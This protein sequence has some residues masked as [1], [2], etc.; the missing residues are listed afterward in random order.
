[1]NR[2][3]LGGFTLIEL[4]VVIA[5]IAILAAILFPL[6]SSAKA[7][8]NQQRCL[9][10]LRQLA[11]AVAMYAGDN[12]GRSPNPRVCIKWPSWEGS[13]G[14]KQLVYPREGQIW[15]YLRNNDVY[16]CP[17][18]R[19]QPAPEITGKPKNYALSYSMNYMF[20]DT[21]TRQTVILDTMRRP[22]EVLLL[23]HESREKINDGDFNWGSRWDIPTK[24]HYE[25]STV[26]YV[27][28]HAK[29]CSYDDLEDA[30]KSSIWDPTK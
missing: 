16:L 25:G 24:V 2:G 27:D 17:S 21:S 12:S 14:T 3:R 15:P 10:N 30:R 22:K 28:T 26:V 23:I 18:D 9:A 7:R 1:M 5:I 8:A 19:N 29:Y 20:I 6:L 11:I 13:R 4:L